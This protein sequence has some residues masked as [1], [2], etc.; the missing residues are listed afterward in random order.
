MQIVGYLRV[1]LKQSWCSIL[2]VEITI[3]VLLAF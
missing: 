1:G 3:L 2:E